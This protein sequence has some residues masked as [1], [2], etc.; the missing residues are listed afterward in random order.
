MS[1]IA[2]YEIAG[3]M[4]W[5]LFA[6]SFRYEHL[7]ALTQ[8]LFTLKPKEPL[9]LGIDQ[10]YLALLVDDNHCIRCRF[11]QATELLFGL[12]AFA[13]LL[14]DILRDQE[15]CDN[16][17]GGVATGRADEM[18]NEAL[19]IPAD[20]RQVS[21]PAAASGGRVEHRLR[22]PGLESLRSMKAQSV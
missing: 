4:P 12:L 21:G 1:R 14:G 10:D 20:P 8:E 18:R 2:L 16:L 15:K 9:S 19:S 22:L 13:D 3:P 17:P 5:M 11:E 7:Y 6:E